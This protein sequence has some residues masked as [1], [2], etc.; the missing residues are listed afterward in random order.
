MN[1][2]FKLI[3]NSGAQLFSRLVST[4]SVLIVTFLITQN[5]SKE[6][7]GD[8]VTITA[9]LALFSLLA[10]FGLNGIV[11]KKAVAD[12][13]KASDYFKE[14]FGLRL[15]LSLISIFLA[16]AVLSFLPH[17]QTVKLGI[18]VGVFLILLQALFNTATAIFQTKLRW[19]QYAL[20]EIVGSI[21]T[22]LLV[23]LAVFLGGGILWIV[24]VFLLG[25]LAKAALGLYLAQRLFKIRGF[26]FDFSLWKSL[27]LASFPLGLMIV[28]SQINANVDKQ[29]IA[30]SNYQE[31]GG[32]SA[33][34]A[35][36]IYGLA[37]RIFDFAIAL[38]TYLVNAAYPAML[39][40]HKDNKI[41]FSEDVRSVGQKLFAFGVVGTL[42]GWFLAP[43]TVSFFGDYSEAILTLRILLL[44]LPIFFVTSL[45]VWTV[46][47]LN[48]EIFLPFV[49]GFAVLLNLVLN[50]IL[51]PKFGFNAAAA[52]TVVTELVI[53]LALLLLTEIDLDLLGRKASDE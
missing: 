51:I 23:F 4:V 39:S 21:T 30:L 31:I 14:L 19:D 34:V 27:L 40:S 25:N 29:I 32:M 18:I 35:V 7:W 11:V 28:F 17:S 38:P 50:L 37:Y 10:D 52:I 1:F 43:Y 24:T 26:G 46:V 15:V 41:K 44:G 53:F 12:E 6:V 5:L 36:G 8:F 13:E 48:K 47:T 33:A 3:F 16:L 49:Y 9:Y 45:L 42:V 22:L 2:D 20:S